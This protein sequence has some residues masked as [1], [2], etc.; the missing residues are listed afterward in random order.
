MVV[1]SFRSARFL[2]IKVSM[3]DQETLIPKKRGPKPTGQGT[4]VMVRLQ[5]YQ[6]AALD[7]W[8]EAQPEPRLTR[9]EALRRLADLGLTNQ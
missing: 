8:I 7:R 9:P 2:D 3:A 6:L 4:P 5:P 1:G